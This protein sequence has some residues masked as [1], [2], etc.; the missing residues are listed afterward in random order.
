M[1]ISLLLQLRQIMTVK[2]E[3]FFDTSA[4][5]AVIKGLMK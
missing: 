1:L 4:V 5:E 2:K 3:I